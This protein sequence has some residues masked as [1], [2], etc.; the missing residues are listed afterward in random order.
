M[1]LPAN[2]PDGPTVRVVAPTDARAFELRPPKPSIPSLKNGEIDDPSITSRAVA[3]KR[4]GFGAAM[5]D[6]LLPEDRTVQMLVEEAVVRALRE[7]GYRAVPSSSPADGTTPEVQTRIEQLWAWMTPGFWT[8]GLDFQGRLVVSGLPGRPD[9]V[10]ESRISRRTA[11]A[12]GSRWRRVIEEGVEGLIVQ[13]KA[14]LATAPGAAVI[15]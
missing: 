13:I 8:V 4:N 5:G 9:I 2:P 12:S 7:A 6:I 11:G 14:E 10:A 1:E 15:R 3:R